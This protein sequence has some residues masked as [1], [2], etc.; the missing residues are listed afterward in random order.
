MKR[1][2]KEE[3]KEEEEEKLEEEGEELRWKKYPFLC[4][5]VWEGGKEEW[6]RK[7]KKRKLREGR[8]RMEG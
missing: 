1:N 4:Q 8:K 5:P 2:R 7:M 3:E 6:R